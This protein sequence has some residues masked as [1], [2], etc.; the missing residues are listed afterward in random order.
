M[1]LLAGT[2]KVDRSCTEVQ[3]HAVL[4]R[5]ALADGRAASVVI[6]V[7]GLCAPVG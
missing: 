6:S 4:D 5:S 3:S 1:I 2:G 7:L